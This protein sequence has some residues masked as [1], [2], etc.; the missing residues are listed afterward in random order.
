[1]KVTIVG[2]VLAGV[3]AATLLWLAPLNCQHGIN[4]V[5]IDGVPYEGVWWADREGGSSGCVVRMLTTR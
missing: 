2:V 5:I 4:R 3:L 1:M